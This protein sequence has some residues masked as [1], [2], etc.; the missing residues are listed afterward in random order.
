MAMTVHNQSVWDGVV[1][2]TKFAQD[3]GGDP[4]LWAIHLSSSLNS[5]GVQLPSTELAEL[6]VSYICW[7][8]NV[9][10]MWKFL[11]KAL[12]MKIVPPVLVLALLSTR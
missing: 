4:M 1:E 2:L 11:E 7:E 12:V 10:I 5:A 3:R 6:L 9:P 8:N